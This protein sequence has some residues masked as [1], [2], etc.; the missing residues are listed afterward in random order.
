MEP[1]VLVTSA[2]RYG[3]TEE[4]AQAVAKTLRESGV[5]V[6]T[7]PIRNVYTLEPYGAV[8]LGVP[9]YMGLLHKDAR[10]FLSA[11]RN[12]LTKMP[13]ALFV[14]GPVQTDQK[15]RSEEHTSEL[16]S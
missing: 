15:D 14:L 8:V 6:E 7:Q 16:Q 3:S 12:A 5:A 2:T 1:I 10:R 13:V 11:H 4:E 9:L